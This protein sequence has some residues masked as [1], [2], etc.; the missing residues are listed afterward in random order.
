[1][2]QLSFTDDNP[3]EIVDPLRV[4]VSEL[5]ETYG[6]YEVDLM[7]RMQTPTLVQAS[8]PARSTDPETSHMAAKRE[9]D[10][11]RFSS[12]SRQAKLLYTVSAVEDG[13]TDQQ[14]AAR[15][16]GS[17]AAISAFEGCRRRMS[18]LRAAR[19]LYDTG[20]RRKNMGSDDESIVWALSDAGRAA[21]IR[22]DE[23]GWSR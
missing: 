16:V 4:G 3:L 13:L 17:G 8:A 2:S 5:I 20:K 9:Q 6:W 12:K 19:F 14:A 18:D 10:V 21:L 11:G 22:L 15:I 23:T 1:M 7:V